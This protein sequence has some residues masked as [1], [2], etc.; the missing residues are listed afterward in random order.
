MPHHPPFQPLPAGWTDAT[1]MEYDLG[2]PLLLWRARQMTVTRLLPVLR[3]R[4][5]TEPQWRLLRALQFHGVPMSQSD[6]ARAAGFY[7]THI[8][9][10]VEYLYAYGAVDWFKKDT[11]R[12]TYK[13][14]YKVGITPYGHKLIAQ[15]QGA[16]AERRYNTS[17]IFGED[18]RA[19]L[20]D[21][22]LKYLRSVSWSP[23]RSEEA[24]FNPLH[25][26]HVNMKR[27]AATSYQLL[28]Q[29]EKALKEGR[30]I[31]NRQAAEELD[32]V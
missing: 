23:W 19:A 12:E 21:L 27:R 8:R 14:Q 22:L 1:A 18:D 16:L 30:Y 31:G 4:R 25:T 6:I 15:V 29:R 32:N 26:H 20:R 9:R 17:A 5:L 28:R 10:M 7:V 11:K 3:D 2:M 13:Q 24:M